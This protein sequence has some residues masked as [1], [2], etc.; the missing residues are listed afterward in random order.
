MAPLPQNSTA[1][2]WTTYATANAQHVV[3]ARFDE[4]VFTPAD[5]VTEFALLFSDLDSFFYAISIIKA[6]YA[7]TGDDV[8]LPVAW[9][10]SPTYGSGS[11]PVV[12][13]P[14]EFTISGKDN[15][16]RRWHQS[17]FG[18]NVATPDRYRILRGDA[19]LPDIWINRVD[20]EAPMWLT[21]SAF[22]PIFNQYCNV[23]FN[24]EWVENLR[25]GS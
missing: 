8:R 13:T 10:G 24:D 2:I 12:N 3:Q 20:D 6:E 17:L 19:N 1:R 16:G 4:S 11:E 5:A 25:Q 15:A 23:G 21:I 14:R 18:L 7:F 9:T 22:T